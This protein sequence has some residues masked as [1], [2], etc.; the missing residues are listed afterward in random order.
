MKARDMLAAS[1][2]VLG[3][4]TGVAKAADP[5]VQSSCF[6]H[7]HHGMTCMYFVGTR[8][9]AYSNSYGTFWVD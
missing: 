3:M 4:S 6:D 5:F 8:L 7:V 9:V 1:L 2:L